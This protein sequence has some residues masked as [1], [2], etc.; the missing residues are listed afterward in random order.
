[1]SITVRL[2][3]QENIEDLGVQPHEVIEVLLEAFRD[4]SQGRFQLPPK[5]ALYP[6]DDNLRYLHAM[7]A[8]LE[9]LDTC[10]M[11][12]L[13]R[14]GSDSKALG[15]PQ[16]SGFQILN[17]MRTGIP[18]A[19][20]D[21]S[22]ITAARTAGT[23]LLAYSSLERE[24][25]KSIAIF[26]TGLQARFHLA[27]FLSTYESIESVNIVSSTPGRSEEF[28]A[29]QDYP[30]V[31]VMP[32]TVGTALAQSDVSMF[33]GW[34]NGNVRAQQLKQGSVAI[35]IE[36]NRPWHSDVWEQAKFVLVDDRKQ[37]WERYLHDSDAAPDGVK[38]DMQLSETLFNCDTPGTHAD[39]YTLIMNVGTGIAD[40]AVA[41]L[42]L[43]KSLAA[44]TGTPWRVAV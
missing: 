41:D 11:K 31:S 43:K 10:G 44:N 7:P 34:L 1:M 24:A 15:L 3:S 30:G 26:G 9:S 38:I 19:I 29:E 5:V 37:L 6:D 16:F 40:L 42:I 8:L 21:C 14:A 33:V 22:W 23:S 18:L 17:D 28:A 20:L 27:Y 25:P 2:L 32:S 35:S 12:W 39:G 13:T 36:M 4:F